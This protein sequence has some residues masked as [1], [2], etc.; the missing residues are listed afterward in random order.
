MIVGRTSLLSSLDQAL[1][2]AEGGRSCAVLL[3]GAPGMGKSAVL[4][5]ARLEGLRRGWCVVMAAAPEDSSAVA[6]ALVQDLV[7]DLLARSGHLGDGDHEALAGLVEPSRWQVHPVATALRE[8]LTDTAAECPLLALVD[9]LQWADDESLSALALA[10]A[11]VGGA[12]VA[13]VA[14]GWPALGDDPRLLG[15]TH[16]HLPALSEP[17]AVAVLASVVSPPLD[18]EQAARAARSLGGCPLALVECE[19]LLTPDQLAGREPMPEVVPVGERL[20]HEWA[21]V[22]AALPQRA[23]SGLR[24]LSVLDSSHPALVHAVL[25]AVGCTEADL[26]PAVRHGLLVSGARGALVTTNAFV[27]AAVLDTCSPADVRAMH[28][29][30]ADIAVRTASPPAV[31]IYHLR[32]CAL[33]G[34]EEALRGLEEQAERAHS[35]AQPEVEARAWQAAAELTREPGQQ[36]S[37]A[38]RAAR[39]WL[40]EASAVQGARPLLALLDE[41]PLSADDAVWREWT[42]AEV[43]AESDLAESAAAALMAAR[44][45]EGAQPAL[46][47][48]LLWDA[49][50]TGWMADDAALAVAAATRLMAWSTSGALVDGAQ[51]PA[52]LAPAVLGAAYLHAGRTRDG[53]ALVQAARLG[54]RDWRSGPATPLSQLVNVVALDELMVADGPEEHARV[55]ALASRSADSGATTSSVLTIQGWRACRRGDWFVARAHAREAVDLARAVRA[56]TQERSALMLLAHVVH[57]TDVEDCDQGLSADQA[58]ARLRTLASEVGDRRA[59]AA[60]DRVTG[61]RAL[62]AGRVDEAAVALEHARSTRCRGRGTADARLLGSVDLVEALVRTGD[63]AAARA[64]AQDVV[65]ELMDVAPLD[66]T[67]AALAARA[68]ALVGDDTEADAQFSLASALHRAGGDAFEAARTTMLWGEHLRRSRRAAAGRK[69]LRGAALAMDRLGACQWARR[70]REQARPGG[71]GTSEADPQWRSRLTAQE[72]RVVREVS[73]GS[74]N[75]E[76][77]ATLAL[78][79]RTVECHLASAYRKLGVRNRVELTNLLR[80]RGDSQGGSPRGGGTDH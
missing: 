35:R 64:L 7:H 17:D 53:V 6:F 80:E 36:A 1:D 32:R 74:T 2:A 54:A 73:R 70:A 28:R 31:A 60:A 27:R 41:A 23:Q 34:D 11:R 15:W 38:V 61:L 30:V 25:A 52:W 5:A 57:A 45:A 10:A 68:R 8:L 43:L 12:R 47:P 55:E 71:R 79:A 67:A 16:L 62:A 63:R 76:A 75:A 44:H 4:D 22:V 77:A 58:L 20:R 78:S 26:E 65:A 40:S 19:R 72:Q 13:V 39:V 59:L 33:V 51:V 49:A 42:R 24:A 14:S 69:A 66:P 37:L 21:L 56:P 3:L 46:V 29:L 9:D 50:A 18:A 48:W